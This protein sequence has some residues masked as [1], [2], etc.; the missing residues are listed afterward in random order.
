M[1]EGKQTPV[2]GLTLEGSWK[3]GL[4]AGMPDGRQ[5]QLFRIGPDERE[6]R[7][8]PAG[9][10]W[11]RCTQTSS[12]HECTC[13]RAHAGGQSGLCAASASA[14]GSGT[15]PATQVLCRYGMTHF[16]ASMNQV[17]PGQQAKLPPTDSR[18]RPDLRT[19]EQGRV[20]EVTVLGPV[21]P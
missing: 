2:G 9:L 10:L 17:V 1:V 6:S 8:V 5:L 21:M 12:F 18:Q 16:V 3:K 15:K 14:G 19:L 13:C 11:N 4:A 20:K 7:W